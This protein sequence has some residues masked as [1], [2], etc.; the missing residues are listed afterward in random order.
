M[1]VVVRMSVP[2]YE[3]EC[4]ECGS[5]IQYRA[6]EVSFTGY[7]TCPVCGMSVWAQTINPIKYECEEPK[8][9]KPPKG[10]DDA[11]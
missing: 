8:K 11:E 6:A 3:T 5:I 2:I 1:T 9:Q 7:I 10:E 4:G